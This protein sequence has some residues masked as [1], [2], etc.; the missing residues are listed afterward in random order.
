M[1]AHGQYAGGLPERTGRA[2][3]LPRRT[4]WDVGAEEGMHLGPGQHLTPHGG[5][6]P[7][8]GLVELLGGAIALAGVILANTRP[9]HERPVPGAAEG[10]RGEPVRAAGG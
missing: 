4:G 2:R 5:A 1:P 6:W 9:R 7:R 10:G 3:L 8:P